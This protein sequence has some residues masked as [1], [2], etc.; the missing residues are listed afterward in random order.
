MDSDEWLRL[1]IEQSSS[2]LLDDENRAYIYRLQ[3]VLA[4][5]KIFLMLN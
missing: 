2:S 3:N 4:L 1:R 5:F